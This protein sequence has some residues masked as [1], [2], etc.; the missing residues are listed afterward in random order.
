M[1][2]M[3]FI[4]GSILEFKVPIDLGYAYCKILDFRSIRE[5]DGVL[6]KVFDCI[7][8]EPIK[9][10][11]ILRN[12]DW[13]FGA[14]RMPWLPGTRGKGAW[15]IKGVLIADDDD[16]IPDFKYCI[17]SS[18]FVEDES[19]LEPWDAAKNINNYIPCSYEKIKHLEDTVVSPRPAIEIRAA[20]EYCRIHGMDIKK[21]FDLGKTI[22]EL[23]YKHSSVSF[24]LKDFQLII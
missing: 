9:D 21:H 7:V 4:S 3:D 14:R 6:A 8:K 22:N 10:I 11:N 2:K 16:I 12:K 1:S 15:K 17:K 13:L 23:I 19:K 18:P 20:M 24:K 5:F